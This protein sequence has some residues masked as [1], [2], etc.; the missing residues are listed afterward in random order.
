MKLLYFASLRE[1]IGKAGENVDIP[2]LITTP[3]EVVVWLSTQG[4]PYKTAFENRDALRVA[5]NQRHCTWD[6]PLTEAN[7]IAFFPPMTGG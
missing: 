6:A 3:R 4:E 2:Y 7:E 1:A 5:I